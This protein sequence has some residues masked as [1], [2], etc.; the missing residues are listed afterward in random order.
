LSQAQPQVLTDWLNYGAS[1]KAYTRDTLKGYRSAVGKLITE[2]APRDVLT[3]TAPDLIAY[4]QRHS[5]CL[6]PRSRAR[7]I[8]AIRAF[9]KWAV[10][11]GRVKK[12]PA[13]KMAPPAFGK[14]RRSCPLGPVR[15]R[16]IEACG[17]LVDPTR[18]ALLRAMFGVMLEA[19][20]RPEETCS[21]QLGDVIL[22]DGDSH[23]IVQH[24]KGNKRREV[25]AC[26]DLAEA[27]RAWLHV[28]RSKEPYFFVHGPNGRRVS[29][30]LLRASLRE[31]KAI[32]GIHDDNLTPHSCRHSFATTLSEEGT[33]IEVIQ[34]LLGH[35]N[36]DTTRQYVHPTDKRKRA[37]V[38]LLNQKPETGAKKPVKVIRLMRRQR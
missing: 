26:D 21:L 28:R 13:L 34:D 20:L 36:I 25:D 16:L 12:N 9:Y 32:A 18:C 4:D 23:I 38:Q 8:A 15:A 29:Q 37:A 2:F 5:R 33:D 35:A 11:E 22:G 19:G 30:Y 14:S 7:D 6:A 17:R 3:L 24:G 10:E 31:I 1:E 27:L